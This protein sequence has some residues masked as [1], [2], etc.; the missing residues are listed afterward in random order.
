[1]IKRISLFRLLDNVRIKTKLIGGFA[2]GSLVGIAIGA[3]GLAQIAEVNSGVR[4]L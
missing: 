3:A 2:I 1:M 4:E